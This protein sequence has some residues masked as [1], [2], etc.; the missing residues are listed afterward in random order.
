M[1][2]VIRFCEEKLRYNNQPLKFSNQWLSVIPKI[3]S[4]IETK[5]VQILIEKDRQVGAST[6]MC[7]LQLALSQLKPGYR[8]I[9][10]SPSFNISS[11][12]S[13][14]KMKPLIYDAERGTQM[15][16]GGVLKSCIEEQLDWCPGC[17][18]STSQVFNNKSI[19][20]IE[21][22]GRGAERLRGRTVDLL[23]L[24]EYTYM[25]DYA[26]NVASY[27]A[28]NATIIFIGEFEGSLSG[29]VE[30]TF[31]ITNDI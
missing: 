30:H 25:S 19:I 2:E 12:I 14:Y 3:E 5:P 10:L 16:R 27:V 20:N 6:N 11:L 13:K 18:T 1:S 4:L 23:I 8:S 28:S 15:R 31:R 21:S 29:K 22:I 17:N 26:I 24:D 7:A 9:H